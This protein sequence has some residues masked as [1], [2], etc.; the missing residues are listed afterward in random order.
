MQQQVS[1]KESQAVWLAAKYDFLT[2]F[3]IRMPSSSMSSVQG[4]PG[5][6]PAT[7]R[8]ALVRSSIELFGIEYTKNVLFPVIRAAAIAI[9]PPKRVAF[10]VQPLHIYKSV[11]R[12]A[13][14]DARLEESVGY[15][16]FA[17]ADDPL[18]IY[19]KVPQKLVGAFH[20]SLQMISYWGQGNSL[21]YC[22]GIL[23]TSP[24][25]G[26]YAIPMRVLDNTQVL[27]RWTPCIVTEF[28]DKYVAWDEIVPGEN[29]GHSTAIVLEVYAFPMVS[30]ERR[31]HSRLL[32]ASAIASD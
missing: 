13:S 19:I 28:R 7:V 22:S 27:Q 12:K 31:G 5:P 11:T 32:T 21:A 15:R 8:L 25:E 14:F 23:C 16:E 3:S 18:T 4:L 10:S 17:H 2:T 6:G 20:G 26:Q 29:I 1:L 9:A 24:K 30:V